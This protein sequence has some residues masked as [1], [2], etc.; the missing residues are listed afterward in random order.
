[1]LNLFSAAIVMLMIAH[2]SVLSKES[3]EQCSLKNHITSLLL[4]AI[5][6]NI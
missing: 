2:L 4:T 3:L 5:K 6:K 1:M